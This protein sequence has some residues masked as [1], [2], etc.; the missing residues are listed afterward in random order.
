[1]V[2]SDFKFVPMSET[3]ALDMPIIEEHQKLIDDGK[4]TDAV[5]LLD[6]NNYQSGFR[7]SIFNAIRER[8]LKIAS[9]VLNLTADSEEYYS[10]EEP[11]PAFM[12]ENGK[13]FW[14][15]LY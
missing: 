8:L 1:M 12:K 14:I 4:Y 13:I 2:N 11:D 5:K 3:K 7:A 15:Q 6:D 9:F 10:T